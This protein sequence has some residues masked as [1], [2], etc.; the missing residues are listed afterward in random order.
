MPFTGRRG[1]AEHRPL[2][3]QTVG[4]G[5]PVGEIEPFRQRHLNHG[6]SA[7]LPALFGQEIGGGSH[8]I[9]NIGP[10]ITRTIAIPVMGAFQIGGGDEL[11]LP[12]RPSPGTG[13]LLAGGI[14][15]IDHL[16]DGD[17]LRLGPA[18]AAA[19]PGQGRQRAHRVEIPGDGT[20]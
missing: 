6:W 20:K 11:H 17:Q 8:G 9:A 16:G 15:L 4:R 12:H 10:D 5:V 7:G 19:I 13:Q 14:A 2:A 3:D 18:T 1:D